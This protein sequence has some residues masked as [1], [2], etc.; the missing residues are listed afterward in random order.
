MF[1]KSCLI[2]TVV[3]LVMVIA[4]CQKDD[5][6]Q[7]LPPTK[8]E[9]ISSSTWR[10]DTAGIDADKNGS[11]DTLLPPGILENCVIKTILCFQFEWLRN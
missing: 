11:M 5:N 10:F 8:T 6:T 3:I 4:S 2:T 7:T 1:T 9:L